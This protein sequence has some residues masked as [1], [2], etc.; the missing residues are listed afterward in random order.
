M[1]VV[2]AK[3]RVGWSARQRLSRR[4]ADQS[5][6]TL[7]QQHLSLGSEL[8]KLNGALAVLDTFFM[9]CGE[10]AQHLALVR[11]LQEILDSARNVSHGILIL[12]PLSGGL[13]TVP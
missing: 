7:L 3:P 8:A 2:D 6:F 10:P 1:H 5:G 11:L 12:T 4:L 13:T 9:G